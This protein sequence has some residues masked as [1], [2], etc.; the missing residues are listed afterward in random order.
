MDDTLDDIHVNRSEDSHD[1]DDIPM[2]MSK[3]SHEG[4]KRRKLSI[5]DLRKACELLPP[6]VFAKV[7][8]SEFTQDILISRTHLHAFSGKFCLSFTH[9]NS[10]AS[11]CNRESKS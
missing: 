8:T 11:I 2:Q 3:D 1:M 5:E 7:G 9:C 6:R 4:P 10:P